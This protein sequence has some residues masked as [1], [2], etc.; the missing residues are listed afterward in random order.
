[1]S[2]AQI[3]GQRDPEGPWSR[4]ALGTGGI[5]VG[6]VPELFRSEEHGLGDLIPRIKALTKETYSHDEIFGQFCQ[7]GIHIDCPVDMAF[8]YLANVYSLEEFT[9]SLREFRHVGGGLYRGIDKIAGGSGETV[10]YLR[11]DAYPETR[12]VDHTCAWDQGGELWMRYHFRFLDAMPTI[13]KAGAIMLWTN[14]KHPY[15]DR[16]VTDIPDYISEPRSRT[17]RAW[18]GD[19]WPQFDAIH[20]IEAGNLKAILE[21]RFAQI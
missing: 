11:S 15:Y 9:F 8:E 16:N 17:D 10:I 4:A 3:S 6:E 19:I 13:R 21:H 7:L 2:A 18:V 20:K 12:V 1:M 5:D 14:C